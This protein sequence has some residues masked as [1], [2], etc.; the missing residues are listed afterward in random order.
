VQN[1]S[2][3]YSETEMDFLDEILGE[4]ECIDYSQRDYNYAE[5]RSWLG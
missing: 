4:I 3:I 5:L 1:G 2:L